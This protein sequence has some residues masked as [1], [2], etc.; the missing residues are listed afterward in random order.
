VVVG[1]DVA[2]GADDDARAE[3]ALRRLARLRQLPLLA[4]AAEE[5]AQGLVVEE[6]VLA[7]RARQAHRADGDDG[8]RD[9]RH[10]VRVR[11]VVDRPRGRAARRLRRG[12]QLERGLL[13]APAAAAERETQC[14]DDDERS[15]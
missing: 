9:A 8:R 13:R 6:R 2:V 5:V 15:E 12:R 7:R 14:D 4:A 10:H 1:D 3:R 11:V